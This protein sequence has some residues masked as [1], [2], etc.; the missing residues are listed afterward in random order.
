M[1]SVRGLSKRYGATPAVDDL[2]FE[3]RSGLVTGFLG[4]NGAG[5]STTMRMILGLDHPSAGVA[6]VGGVPYRELRAPLRTVGAVLD[7]RAVHPGRSVGQHL[8]AF[9]RFG[10]IPGRRVREVIGQLGLET[11]AGRRAGSLSAAPT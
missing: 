7:A 8:L 9:A 3:V 6:L 5:K 11:V 2:T 4:P 10:G 1:I